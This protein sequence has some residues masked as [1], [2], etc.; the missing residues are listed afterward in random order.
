[1]G[2]FCRMRSL[3]RSSISADKPADAQ[4]FCSTPRAR[5]AAVLARAT[6]SPAGWAAL[7]RPCVTCSVRSPRR[8]PAT[9]SRR[10]NRP[11]RSLTRQIVRATTQR[12]A[13]F[14]TAT[15]FGDLMTTAASAVRNTSRGAATSRSGRVLRLVRRSAQRHS[16]TPPLVGG[17]DAAPSEDAAR[18]LGPALSVHVSIILARSC[19]STAHRPCPDCRD[20]AR[21]GRAAR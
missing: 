7:W 6:L 3:R 18:D 9:L 21:G 12:A 8:P 13:P 1:M 19:P 20:A 11:S 10:P 14:D 15:N 2:H 17:H 4:N 16:R 5:T